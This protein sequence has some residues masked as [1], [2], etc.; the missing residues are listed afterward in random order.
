[1]GL[2]Y[3]WLSD[4]LVLEKKK[5]LPCFNQKLGVFGISVSGWGLK[6]LEYQSEGVIGDQEFHVLCCFDS[7]KEKAGQE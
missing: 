2:T 1:M 3:V 4:V 7:F 5:S 6:L